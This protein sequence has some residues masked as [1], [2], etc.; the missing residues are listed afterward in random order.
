MSRSERRFQLFADLCTYLQDAH[1]KADERGNLQVA[2]RGDWSESLDKNGFPR[3]EVE[4]PVSER[5]A[6]AMQEYEEKKLRAT[7]YAKG[8]EVCPITTFSRCHCRK[9]GAY[10]Q[11][12]SYE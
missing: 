4:G 11:Q 8:A 5:T 1:R 7:S 2:P 10:Y 6:R 9:S 12:N 3:K